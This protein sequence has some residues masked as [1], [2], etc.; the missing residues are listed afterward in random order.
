MFW[1]TKAKVSCNS[2]SASATYEHMSSA[3]PSTRLQSMAGGGRPGVPDRSMPDT[4]EPMTSEDP[5]L[6]CITQSGAPR[7]THAA[8]THHQAP[9]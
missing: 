4:T 6:R 2:L 7:N 5:G 3:S 8:T 9:M 1:S